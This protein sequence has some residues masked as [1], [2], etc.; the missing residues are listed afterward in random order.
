MNAVKP[1]TGSEMQKQAHSLCTHG[2][3]SLVY[4]LRAITLVYLVG[5][6]RLLRSVSPYIENMLI[7]S[8]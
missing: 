8:V 4:R 1:Q 2:R 5:L 3:Y 7:V 6:V